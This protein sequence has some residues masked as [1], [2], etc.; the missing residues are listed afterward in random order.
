MKNLSM[1]PRMQRLFIATLLLTMGF[2][3]TESAAQC[4]TPPSGLVSWWPGNGNANDIQS[5]NHGAL[6]N[7]ATFASGTVEQAF[8]FDG[9]DDF[10]RIEDNSNLR[11]G[12]GEITIDAWI[13]ASSGNTFRAI[14]AKVGLSFPYPGYGLRIADDNK[15]EFIATDCGTGS[16]GFSLPGGGGSRQPVRSITVVAD[17]IFHHV[18]GVRRSDGTLEIYVDGILENTRLEPLRNTDSADPF[19]IGDIDAVGPEQPFNGLIDEASIY[20]RALSAAEIQ[21]IYNA[22]GAGKCKDIS[23]PVCVNPPSGLVS[24]WP[25]ENNAND[26]QS[27]NHG[28]LQNGVTFVAGLIDQALSFDGVDD[29]VRVEHSSS[30]NLAEHTIDAWI[31][32]NVQFGASFHGIVVKQNPNNTQRNYYLGLQNDGR[33]HYSISYPSPFLF[34]DSNTSIQNGVWTHITATFDG[35]VMRIYINGQQDAFLNVGSFVPETTTQPLLIGSTNEPAQTFFNGQIDETSIFNRALS[36]SEIQALFNAGSA[37][38]CKDISP[39]VCVNP[40]SGLI[41]WWPG[42]D[43]ANDIKGSNHG[44]LQNGAT[45]AVGKVGQAFSFD[46]IDDVVNTPLT[47][48]YV[49]GV[50]LDAWVKTTDDAG[51]IVSDGGGASD[52]AGMGLFI[53][54]GGKIDLFGSKGTSGELNFFVE[55]PVISDGVFHHIAAT[56]AGD[57]TS[58]GAKLYVDG[59]LV[60]TATALAAIS[61]GSTSIHIGWHTIITGHHKFAGLID[62]A[63]IYNRALSA[64]EIQSLYNAGSAGK[65]KECTPPEVSITGSESVCPN[66]THTYTANIDVAN[67]TFEWSVTGGTINGDNNGSS[68]SVTAGGA[69]TMVVSVEVTDGA[70]NCSNSVTQNVTVEDDQAPVITTATNPITLWPPN[71]QYVTI[72]VSQCVTAVTDNCATLSTNNVIITKVTSD[73]P[74]DA[75]GG[76]DGNTLNDMVIASNCQS[77]QLR[78]EREGSGNGRVYTIHLSVNDGNGNTGTAIRL[79][80]VPKSQNGNPAINDGPA[81]TVNGSCNGSLGKLAGV[82][83][84]ENVETMTLPEDYALEQNYPNPFNPSTVISFQLPVNSDVELTIYSL[85]GQLVR[86]LVNGEMNAGRHAISWDGRDRAGNTVAAG[87]YLYRL[88]AQGENG[89]VVFAQTR[90]MAFLK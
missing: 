88:V 62:E 33:I 58:N 24:W 43:N 45:F 47:V 5:S 27:G 42:D 11:L 64:A 18:T 51:L 60:G 50:T 80:T 39:P 4:V 17:N 37:G 75:K 61:T 38:K 66:T 30:L 6:Q 3:F 86:E 22:G 29:Y 28:T 9:A 36:A 31:N 59:T 82:S 68:V 1:I 25:G 41:S 74:E 71:H 85:T 14:A 76:G 34:L 90:R 40:P 89:E 87:M 20:N 13:K 81:Y 73:E 84:D 49:G 72:N 63:S 48:S 56:W 7:G 8:S 83:S 69:S 77:V 16:C 55:G 54:S 78:S 15:V 2:T 65:C 23:P 26:I 67:A 21:S 46:G 70:T 57:V 10:I 52:G 53:E 19:T 79:V 44:T 35:S 12:A 32:P